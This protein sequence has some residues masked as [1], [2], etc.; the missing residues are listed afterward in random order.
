MAEALM[1][2]GELSRESGVSPDVLRA[3]E[4]RYGILAPERTSG[5]FRLYGGQDL[6][7]VKAMRQLVDSGV[8]ASEAARRVTTAA[9]SP[10]PSAASEGMDSLRTS[11]RAVLRSFDDAG[12]QALIDDLFAAYDLERVITAVIIPELRALGEEWESGAASV[13]QEHFAV[14]LLRGRLLGLAR[15]WDR[16][17]GPRLVLACPEGERHDISLIMFGLIAH[18]RGWRVTFLGADT[19]MTSVAAAA[20]AVHADAIVLYATSPEALPIRAVLGALAAVAPVYI[21]GP[22]GESAPAPAQRL[23]GSITDGAERLAADRRAS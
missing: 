20:S 8:P 13:G 17:I 14:N 16:G 2:I 19:P 21:A 22:G 9:P 18:R 6:E 11:L 10:A 12:S 23:T 3:W 4:R 15:G 5:G 7:R 1:R